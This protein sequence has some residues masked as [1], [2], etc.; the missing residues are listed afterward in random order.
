MFVRLLRVYERSLDKRERDISSVN[1]RA[2]G[3]F[4][5]SIEAFLD[6]VFPPVCEICR[7]DLRRVEAPSGY[8]PLT[9]AVTAENATPTKPVM[10]CDHCI[11]SLTSLDL[12]ACPRCGGFAD[13]HPTETGCNWCRREEFAFS[14]VIA[15]APYSEAMAEAV[16]KSKMPDGNGL[17]AALAGLLCLVRGEQL[18]ELNCDLVIPIPL[19]RSQMAARGTC[20]PEWIAQEVARWLGIPSRIG[21][22]RRV[23]KTRRQRGLKRQARFRNVRGAFA[24]RVGWTQRL[25]EMLLRS[26][27]YIMATRHQARLEPRDLLG[28]RKILLVDDVLTTGATCHEAA[29]T[30]RKAGAAEV[31]VT[32]LARAQGD[33]AKIA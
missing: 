16:L 1:R 27:R 25:T 7:T 4:D 3:K 14:R 26:V 31:A 20:G 13:R 30:I 5:V 2:A 32:V 19:H 24:V 18:R 33:H 15:L 29:K 17:C 21:L 9:D 22:L 6:L 8:G 12:R 28:G 10:L 23:R 11:A